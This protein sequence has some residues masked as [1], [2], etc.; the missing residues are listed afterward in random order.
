MTFWH[1]SVSKTKSLVLFDSRNKL[2]KFKRKSK[3]TED[4]GQPVQPLLKNQKP[5][6]LPLIFHVCGLGPQFPYLLND[7]QASFSSI[8]VHLNHR[9]DGVK[10]KLLH[11]TPEFLIQSIWGGTWEFLPNKFPGHA[12]AVRPRTKLWEPLVSSLRSRFLSD[13]LFKNG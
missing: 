8:C 9:E 12:D 13:A 5:L 7:V 10:Q 3:V 1:L 11:P 6:I 2:W 4:Q